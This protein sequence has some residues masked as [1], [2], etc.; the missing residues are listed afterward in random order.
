MRLKIES[1]QFNPDSA[2]EWNELKASLNVCTAKVSHWEKKPC[3][4]S[5]LLQSGFR[6]WAINISFNL[7]FRE[8][9]NSRLFYL[10]GCQDRLFC[11]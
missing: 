2:L 9:K 7:D 11:D 3:K 10:C 6:H 4:C 1:V 5:I 8:V